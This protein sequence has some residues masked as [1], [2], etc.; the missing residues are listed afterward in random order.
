MIIYVVAAYT[1]TL[2]LH[3]EEIHLLNTQ[4]LEVSAI[5]ITSD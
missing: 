4:H 2:A 3:A 1:L 5:Y